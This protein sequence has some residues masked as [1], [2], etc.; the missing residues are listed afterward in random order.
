M[1]K[2]RKRRPKWGAKLP[3]NCLNCV[4]GNRGGCVEQA[5]EEYRAEQDPLKDFIADCCVVQPDARATVGGLYEAYTVWCETN[6]IRKPMANRVFGKR[7]EAK[8]YQLT[9]ETVGGKRARIRTGIGLLE[10]E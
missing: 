5:S 4:A 10:V 9:F 2:R 6:G 3:K 8:G 1:R 7:L